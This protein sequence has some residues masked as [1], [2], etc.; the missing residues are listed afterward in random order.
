MTSIYRDTAS[1]FCSDKTSRHCEGTN[2]PHKEGRYSIW[3]LALPLLMLD[4]PEASI[5]RGRRILDTKFGCEANCAPGNLTDER[6]CSGRDLSFDKQF[7]TAGLT[8]LSQM[9]IS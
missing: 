9:E 4:F 5:A 1:I 6:K 7:G 3:C 2:G 8:L